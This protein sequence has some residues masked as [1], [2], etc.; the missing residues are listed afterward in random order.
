VSVVALVPAAGR[1][2][3]LGAGVPK[4]LVPVAG[5]PLVVHAVGRL[6]AA[7][8]VSAVVVA[9]P[10]AEVEAIRILVA[11]FDGAVHVITGGAERSHSVRSALDHAQAVLP[12]VR[13][14]LVHDAAR[15]F[16]P[17]SVTEAVVSALVSGLPAVIPVLPVTDTVKQIDH[18]G[19][20]LCTVDRFALRATQTPQGF[21]VDVLRRAHDAATDVAT[22]DAGLVERI[23]IPVSTVPGHP[24][25]MKI[26][27][28]FDLG[29]A[30]A[31]LAEADRSTGSG[32]P[33]ASG[34]EE[35]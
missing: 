30:A 24:H 4:A 8:P 23:G 31:V 19:V 18:R 34:Q 21:T 28:P 29:V 11:R 35:T 15:A 2:E 5:I 17:V 32:R 33:F 27:T 9:A 3:R 7:G 26:T 1:G 13:Y 16:T 6:L 20:V 22:D 10:E 14:V 25:A 12:G